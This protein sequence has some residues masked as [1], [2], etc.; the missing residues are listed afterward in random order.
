MQAVTRPDELQVRPSKL[1]MEGGEANRRRSL[2]VSTGVA[3]PVAL[4]SD[5][6][7]DTLAGG[8]WA[9]ADLCAR[10]GVT[11]ARGYPYGRPRTADEP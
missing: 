4:A 5:L 11:R 10:I 6:V 2:G 3:S 8:T 7:V 9:E 1:S